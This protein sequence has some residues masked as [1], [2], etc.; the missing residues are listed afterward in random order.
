[1]IFIIILAAAVVPFTDCFSVPQLQNG[2]FANSVA[3]VPRSIAID[4][5]SQT[6]YVASEFMT[7]DVRMFL[8]SYS[9]SSF[10]STSNY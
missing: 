1:M 9:L 3:M 8:S 7:S 5:A 10:N 6:L 2:P 4:V